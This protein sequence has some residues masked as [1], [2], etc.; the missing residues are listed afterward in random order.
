MK[1]LKV[2]MFMLMMFP[3]SLFGETGVR[4]WQGESLKELSKEAEGVP[5]EPEESGIYLL[6]QLY[7]RYDPID[8][9]VYKYY[10]I[11]KKVL[12]PI[13]AQ[14]SQ[15]REIQYDS[16]VDSLVLLQ[17]E[18][19]TP[20]GEILKATR[21]E[22]EP[23]FPDEVAYAHLQ[24]EN[25]D[26]GCVLEVEYILRTTKNTAFKFPFRQ[27]LRTLKARLIVDYP[28]DTKLIFSTYN[29]APSPKIKNVKW[30][31]VRMKRLIWEMGPFPAISYS[32]L[33]LGII[34]LLSPTVYVVCPDFWGE[35]T[36]FSWEEISKKLWSDYK[37]DEPP[38]PQI[39]KIAESLVK[40]VGNSLEKIERVLAFVHDSI[41]FSAG[42]QLGFVTFHRKIDPIKVLL[43]RRANPEGKFVLF[44]SLLRSLGFEVFPV[45][46]NSR[47]EVE[48]DT[49]FP[50]LQFSTV[51]AKIELKDGYVWADPMYSGLHVGE[52]EPCLCSTKALEI[53]HDGYR[54]I[55]L[56]PVDPD[57]N[58][59]VYTFRG[60]VF[61]NGVMK[62]ALEGKFYGFPG[63]KLKKEAKGLDILEFESKIRQRF[64]LT[65][66]KII[67]FGNCEW[68]GINSRD[69]IFSFR[70]NILINNYLEKQKDSYGIIPFPWYLWGDFAADEDAREIFAKYEGYAHYKAVLSFEDEVK[71]V[72]DTVIELD[73]PWLYMKRSA[74]E[75]GENIVFEEKIV[76]KVWRITGKEYDEF[77]KF[78]EKVDQIHTS[79]VELVIK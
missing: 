7:V 74:K 15:L 20:Q 51:L 32:V 59:A 53:R 56:P 57:K 78:T 49:S 16:I 42:G 26:T 13:Y 1:Y 76:R 61:K 77:V 71:L 34:T 54:F 79:P 4:E 12:N 17:G 43:R 63:V 38:P 39:R 60:K 64:L 48:I 31:G 70:G 37:L 5:V 40:G 58:G 68:F 14:M 73:S 10:R 33:A 9:A 11:V 2:L 44:S 62:G 69:S 36:L 3:F 25:V 52:I 35:G 41:T 24:Y 72:K 6:N 19:L 45:L 46:A 8:S 29:G 18:M 28:A 66:F 30:K 22:N 55:T 23:S 27:A 67:S 50:V 75:E 47:K 65:G 21:L